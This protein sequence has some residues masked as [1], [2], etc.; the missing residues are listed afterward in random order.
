MDKK[1][2]DAQFVLL[3]CTEP[4][5]K[6]VM[7]EVEGSGLGVRWEGNLVYQH[8]YNDGTL[9]HRFIPVIFDEAD[10][11]YIPTPFQGATYYCLAT[12][13]RYDALYM[14]LTNQIR[15][16]KP[17]L[18]Q[19]RSLPPKPVKTNPAMYITGPIDVDLWNAAGWSGTFFMWAE[20]RDPVLGLGFRDESSARQI[21]KTWHERYGETDNYEELRIS[22]IE[23]DIEGKEPGYSVHVGAAPDA[24]VRRLKDAGYEYDEDLLVMISRIHRMN[25]PSGSMNL[26]SFQ[27]HYRSKKRYI[28]APGV[29]SDNGTALEPMLELGILKGVVHFRHVS[30]LR[31]NDI[32]SVVLGTG[33]VER[34][35][36]PFWRANEGSE[37][38]E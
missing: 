1:I 2:R 37:T 27:E 19:R 8:F 11:P 33:D 15:V 25:P 7:G 30:E 35:M 4:Y 17:E 23:G 21:F 38:D 26:A 10:K 12:D 31:E 14:R 22:I 24:F 20:S 28:L 16:E 9:N 3:I 13:E 18:G 5:F 29:I 34:P 36:S 6:R 32:D